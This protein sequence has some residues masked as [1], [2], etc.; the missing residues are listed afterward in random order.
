[1]RGGN[2]WSDEALFGLR[3]E[4]IRSED[5]GWRFARELSGLRGA[6]WMEELLL[7]VKDEESEMCRELL[8]ATCRLRNGGRV[9]KGRKK[10]AGCG[11]VGQLNN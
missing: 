1:M 4:E 5:R 6:S 11:P 10:P 7:V 3:A 2:G 9:D 8:L